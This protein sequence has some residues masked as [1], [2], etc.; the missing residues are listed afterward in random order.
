VSGPGIVTDAVLAVLRRQR[1]CARV[2]RLG[3]RV[4]YE[5]L[6]ELDRHGVASWADVEPR[7][8]RFASLDPELLR[9]VGAGRFAARPMHAVPNHPRDQ[10]G[11]D[12]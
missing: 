10:E 2:H 9:A 1:L 3:D 8:E 6:D 12:L 4:L 7:L 5:L 11:E